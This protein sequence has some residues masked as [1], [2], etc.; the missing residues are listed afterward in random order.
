VRLALRAV[1]LAWAPA[2]SFAAS[3]VV[4]AESK[5]LDATE[6]AQ[7]MALLQRD[8][9]SLAL[10]LS[11]LTTKKIRDKDPAANDGRWYTSALVSSKPVQ[12]PAGFCWN[13]QY[14]YAVDE[15]SRW[16]RGHWPARAAWLPR[17][18]A[19]G[20]PPSDAIGISSQ[21]LPGTLVAAVLREGPAL[22]DR[23]RAWPLDAQCR[24]AAEHGRLTGISNNVGYWPPAVRRQG[25]A[26]IDFV[27]GVGTAE[28]TFFVL[29]GLDGDR[30]TPHANG[31]AHV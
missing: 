13:M 16:N 27:L 22:R 24:A 11:T 3:V 18:G 23:A 31:C 14:Q 9:E 4:P 29:V 20:Q 8:Q 2:A 17:G 12:D 1:V 19:C 15:Q 6:Q 26:T 10:D 28:K 30:L 25:I 21:G 7:L 5:A